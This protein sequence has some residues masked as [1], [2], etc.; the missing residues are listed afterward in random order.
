MGFLYEFSRKINVPCSDWRPGTNMTRGR[1]KDLAGW[2]SSFAVAGRQSSWDAVGSKE[3]WGRC[4]GWE[5]FPDGQGHWTGAHMWKLVAGKNVTGG[6]QVTKKIEAVLWGCSRGILRW[7]RR[8][9][10]ESP[11]QEQLHK[12]L[13]WLLAAFAGA[14]MP[15]PESESH[16][17]TVER[18]KVRMK[19]TWGGCKCSA[20]L[21]AEEAACMAGTVSASPSK[22]VFQHRED[23]PCRSTLSL[24]LLSSTEKA[25]NFPPQ[26]AADVPEA[27]HKA[28][29][30]GSL[31]GGH[32]RG[33]TSGFHLIDISLLG[34]V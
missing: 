20:A 5:A 31:R 29:W 19:E 13:S 27:G 8:W 18:E 1:M 28:G 9:K 24:S 7:C 34:T 11:F 12:E 33:N 10:L 25:N 4:R 16:S 26:L 23:R 6:L 21:A 3:C 17:I 14:K 2:G 22:V 30:L 32:W 15:T